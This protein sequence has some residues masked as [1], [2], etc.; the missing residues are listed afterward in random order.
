M[1]TLADSLLTIVHHLI[2]PNIKPWHQ[3]GTLH[4][5]PTMPGSWA[6]QIANQLKMSALDSRVKFK[7]Q[8]Y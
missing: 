8:N 6:R 5:P 1:K 7:G 2:G 4:P 3:K